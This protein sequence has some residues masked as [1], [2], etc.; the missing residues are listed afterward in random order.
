M[1]E[2]AENFE[3]PILADAAADHPSLMEKLAPGP[4]R[5]LGGFLDYSAWPDRDRFLEL[6]LAI[7]AKACKDEEEDVQVVAAPPAVVYPA[8]VQPSRRCRA[9]VA[10]RANCNE[11][12]ALT[13]DYNGWRCATH[14]TMVH[15]FDQSLRSSAHAS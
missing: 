8:V 5:S 12:F 10:H 1:M 14:R 13:P 4:W 15:M 11:P 6:D 2:I 9:K 3:Q 7:H